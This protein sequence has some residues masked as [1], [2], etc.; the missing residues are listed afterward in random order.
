M[1]KLQHTFATATEKEDD[2]SLHI[3][4]NNERVSSKISYDYK[5]YIIFIH[6][7]NAISKIILRMRNVWQL[8]INFLVLSEKGNFWNRL[9]SG[10]VCA[11]VTNKRG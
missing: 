6:T 4:Q 1:Y 3:S 8:I 10:Q 11:T 2:F 7:I 9:V 5:N